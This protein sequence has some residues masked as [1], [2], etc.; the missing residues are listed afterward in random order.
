MNS[1]KPD[2]QRERHRLREE[3][4]AREEARSRRHCW[5]GRIAVVSGILVALVLAQV[6]VARQRGNDGP[7][8]GRAV[9]DEGRGHVAEGVPLTYRNLPP[10]SGKHYPYPAL[11][12]ISVRGVPESNWVHNL[13]HGAI[14]VLYRCPGGGSSCPLVAQLQT[15]YEQAPPGKYGQ[16][17]MVVTQ[18]ARLRTP[19]AALAWNRILELGSLDQQQLLAFYRRYVDQG[20]EDAP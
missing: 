9:A 18:D 14:V 1:S 7:E 5:L 16:V 17:K 15:L 10:T 8:L 19:I 20:P 12:G 3:F 13:E 11:Y 4:R 6:V 2:R